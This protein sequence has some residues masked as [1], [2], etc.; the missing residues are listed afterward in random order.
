[1]SWNSSWGQCVLY[2]SAVE[3]DCYL[4]RWEKASV[5]KFRQ[6]FVA[7]LFTASLRTVLS[8]HLNFPNTHKYFT[9]Q[10]PTCPHTA[11]SSNTSCPKFRPVAIQQC[12]QILHAPNSD[13]SPYS[14]VFKSLQCRTIRL[15]RNNATNKIDASS[16]TLCIPCMMF[17]LLFTDQHLCTILYI[18]N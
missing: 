11:V 8:S 1:M 10:I 5:S 17:I 15:I 12:L 13:L 18:Q 14:S 2:P 9:P 16:L 4:N 3:A 6:I 7:G